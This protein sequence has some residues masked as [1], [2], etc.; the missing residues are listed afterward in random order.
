VLYSQNTDALI[1]V[2]DA[3]DPERLEEAK[4]ELERV[5]AEDDL[6]AASVLILAN[7]MDLPDAMTPKQIAK[8]LALD[9]LKDRKWH[10]QG[11]VATK[12]DG[13]YE[14]MDWLSTALK[15]KA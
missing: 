14:G 1:Y 13:L 6:R 4:D 2:V 12:G 3:A 5:L 9:K 15:A 7:K 11:A 10:V 8:G